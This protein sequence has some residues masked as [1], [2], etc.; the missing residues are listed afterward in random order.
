M[1]QKNKNRWLLAGF[2]LAM[3]LAYR[4]SIAKTMDAK[5]RID[6]IEEEMMGFEDIGK[7]SATL[8]AKERYLDSILTK[9][10][11]KNNSVQNSLLDFLNAETSKG[12]V[13]IVN[14]LE[15][16]TVSIDGV[17]VVSYQFTLQGGYREIESIVHKLEQETGYGKV[18]H[19]SFETKRDHRKRKNL[20]EATV[21]VENYNSVF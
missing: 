7:L 21:I 20:L 15:P 4:L 1:T 3:L 14:F 5:K 18:S 13:K 6:A 11:L 9:N 8:H 16:H 2:V 19:V 10:N 12:S 17:S